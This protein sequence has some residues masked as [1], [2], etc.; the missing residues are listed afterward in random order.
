MKNLFILLLSCIAAAFVS[1]AG[2]DLL[3][4]KVDGGKVE[5][6][7][8]GGIYVFKGIPFAAPPV[9][10]LRWKAPQPVRAWD[11]ILK[12]RE[13]APSCPQ[14]AILPGIDQLELSEDCL[15][16]NI[17][18]PAKSKNEKLPVMVWIYGGGFAMGSASLYPGDELAKNGVVFVSI[19][20]RV[21]ALGFLAHPELTAESPN[22]VS[23]NYGL[24][25]QIAALKWVQENIEAFGGDPAKVTV[26]GESAGAIS[27][28]ILCASPLA[29][30]LFRGAI[31]E[32]GGSFGPV[33]RQS[34]MTFLQAG[35][36]PFSATSLLNIRTAGIQDL[37]AA[38]Q[39]GLAFAR[40]MG[41]NSIA[42]LRKMEAGKFVQDPS[43][44]MGGFWP[45]VDGFVI[46]GDQ[47][48]CYAQGRYNDV[49]VLIGTNSDEGSMFVRPAA[50]VA[51]Y[52]KS[53]QERF[54][55]FADRMLTAYPAN[56]EEETYTSAADMFREMLFAWHTFAWANLQSQTGKSKVFVYYFDQPQSFPTLLPVIKGRGAAHASEIDYAFHHLDPH[57]ATGSDVKLSEMMIKYWTNFAKH[58]NPNGE[59]LPAWGTYSASDPFVM[60]LK[61]IPHR[62]DY[63]NKEKLLLMED[64]FRYLRNHE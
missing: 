30:G 34:G 10:E 41:A 22:N 32:S 11:G 31:S 7:L 38:E 3:I 43:A 25:D 39:D 35:G 62:I 8:D 46:T 27:T 9:G 53:V 45:N 40:H 64:Y 2:D 6:T 28:S 20:Y 1:C 24:L 55:G 33:R 63:P 4:V 52:R 44:Q 57:L 5:G 37:Q 48:K 36:Q 18:T 54:G 59:G 15:Y 16:L 13:F 23:G 26:S 56:T 29:K 51:G 21:G 60:L 12:A 58:G 50:S 14:V 19:S 61:D 47:Y 42:G 49:N 17:W